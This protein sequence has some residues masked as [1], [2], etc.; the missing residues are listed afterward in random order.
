MLG[1]SDASVI[2]LN[3]VELVA[4]RVAGR[5][6]LAALA[7]TA[8]ATTAALVVLDGLEV[9]IDDRAGA[10]AA[11][12]RA[13]I[14]TRDRWPALEREFPVGALAELHHDHPRAHALLGHTI[15]PLTGGLQPAYAAV[16]RGTRPLF[17]WWSAAGGFYV[18]PAP[19]ALTTEE[20]SRSSP[21]DWLGGADVCELPCEL[22]QCVDLISL[23]ACDVGCDPG[24]L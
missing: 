9:A 20:T 15:D 23:P 2:V 13:L 14:A 5:S 7:E 17:T 18:P 1:G 6:E 24:C 10:L 8:E 4:R 21:C 22:A 11:F 12:R 19:P 3:R 16:R